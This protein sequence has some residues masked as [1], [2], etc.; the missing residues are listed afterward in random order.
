MTEQQE[1]LAAPRTELQQRFRRYSE[2][3]LAVA[4]APR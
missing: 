4:Q 2:E 3:A 1:Q